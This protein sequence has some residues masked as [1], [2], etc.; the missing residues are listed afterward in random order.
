M[1]SR[2]AILTATNQLDVETELR[3]AAEAAKPKGVI[4]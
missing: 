4:Q 2:R 1:L 3:L